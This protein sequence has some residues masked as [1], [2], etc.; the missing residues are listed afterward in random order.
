MVVEDNRIN[1]NK[2]YRWLNVA[3][4]HLHAEFQWY[5]RQCRGSN[6]KRVK[7]LCF[8]THRSQNFPFHVLKTW[9]YLATSEIKKWLQVI[10]IIDYCYWIT[11]VEFNHWKLS[12]TCRYHMEHINC[13]HSFFFFSWKL[14]VN[15]KSLQIKEENVIRKVMWWD[16]IWILTVVRMFVFWMLKEEGDERVGQ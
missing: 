13:I 9:K 10:V 7:D 4:C 2:Y 3:I 15:F 1:E 14:V 12:L 5:V 16:I 6:S 8:L 11:W